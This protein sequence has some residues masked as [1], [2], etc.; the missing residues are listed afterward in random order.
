MIKK[1]LCFSNPAYI[2]FRKGLLVIEIPEIKELK[3]LPQ[4]LKERSVITR[5]I[6]DI[7]MVIL[8]NRRITITSAA[9]EGLMRNNIAVV[10]CSEN[11]MPLGMHMPLNANTLQDERFRHQ[12][13]ASQPLKK[14]LW[15]QTMK[16]KIKNQGAVLKMFSEVPVGCMERWAEDVKS[17]DTGNVEAKAA[18]YYW[19]YIFKKRK[20]FKRD[21]GGTYPNNLLNY[22]YAILRAIVARALIG[23]GLLPTL[24]IHHHNRYNA[25]C[26]ADDIMEPYRPYVDIIAYKLQEKEIGTVLNKETKAKLLAIATED[27]VIDG[28]TYPL[29]LGTQIT[30]ASLYKCFAGEARKILYPTI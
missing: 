6:E 26:L 13:N 28:K 27:V 30:A 10:T 25:Y 14:Q 2:S 11:G 8:D 16:Q 12:I 5:A 24:G 9:M 3:N 21:R 18:V 23:S 7:S 20:D 29:T 4:R 19:R 22:G 15:Q 1:V 17:G